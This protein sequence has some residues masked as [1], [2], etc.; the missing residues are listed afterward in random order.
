MNYFWNNL[1]TPLPH[2]K[3]TMKDTNPKW[4]KVVGIAFTILSTITVPAYS[5]TAPTPSCLEYGDMQPENPTNDQTPNVQ[6]S[7]SSSPEINPGTSPSGD[8]LRGE[9]GTTGENGEN[10]I[11]GN[12]N[13]NYND[14]SSNDNISTCNPIIS[15][16]IVGVGALFAIVAFVYVLYYNFHIHHRSYN[17]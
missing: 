4:C 6:P 10:P 16:I 17:V 5:Q 1:I 13:N 11:N 2:N 8:N 12:G 14:S 15:I 7:P 3:Y 9:S